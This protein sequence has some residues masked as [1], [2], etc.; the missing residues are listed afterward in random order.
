LF[1]VKPYGSLGFEFDD[2]LEFEWVIDCIYVL[3]IL[4]NENGD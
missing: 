1:F 4:L 3:G 2:I